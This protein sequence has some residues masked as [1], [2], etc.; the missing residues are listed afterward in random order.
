MTRKFIGAAVAVAGALVLFV[1]NLRE[2]RR[3][4]RER[5]EQ[6][7]NVTGDELLRRVEKWTRQGVEA[8]RD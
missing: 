8:S 3:E 4:R 7:L 6:Y 2:R 1:A 5:D